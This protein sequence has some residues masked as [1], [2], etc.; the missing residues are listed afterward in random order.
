MAEYEETPAPALQEK[1]KQTKKLQN[2][3]ICNTAGKMFYGLGRAKKFIYWR[4][5]LTER[6]EGEAYLH[7]NIFLFVNTVEE[8]SGFELAW[9][10]VM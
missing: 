8:A 2:L 3:S 5:T 4:R 10:A 6:V 1:S 7:Q 9:L